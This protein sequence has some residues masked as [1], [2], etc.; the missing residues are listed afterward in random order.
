MENSRRSRVSLSVFLFRYEKR[1]DRRKKSK[2]QKK[3]APL[4]AR[5]SEVYQSLCEVEVGAACVSACVR[6][7]LG[8]KIGAR[9]CGKEWENLGNYDLIDSLSK[10]QKRE[11]EKQL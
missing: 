10:L 1:F 8:E 5:E 6:V 11:K 2:E 9:K 7:C 4:S 3:Q